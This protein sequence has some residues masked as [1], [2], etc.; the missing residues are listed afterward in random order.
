MAGRYSHSVQV[1]IREIIIG[2]LTE[3]IPFDQPFFRL[4]NDLCIDFF[5]AVATGAQANTIVIAFCIFRLLLQ[6]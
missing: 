1:G 3:C 4:Q 5:A 2:Q 6:E